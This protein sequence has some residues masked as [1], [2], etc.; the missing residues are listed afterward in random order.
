MVT[1]NNLEITNPIP[2]SGGPDIPKGL[3]RG[4][5]ALIKSKKSLVD[6]GLMKPDTTEERESAVELD[7][8]LRKLEVKAEESVKMRERIMEETGVPIEV[9][10]AL[11]D[12]IGTELEFAIKKN[13]AEI[14]ESFQ[15]ELSIQKSTI[16]RL[17]QEKDLL[18]SD[19]EKMKVDIENRI[20]QEFTK[21]LE[22]ERSKITIAAKES[23]SP[24][25]YSERRDLHDE[26]EK[27]L[28]TRLAEAEAR[29]E[30]EANTLVNAMAAQVAAEKDADIQNRLSR[31]REKHQKELTDQLANQAAELEEDF[32][33]KIKEI[34][35]KYEMVIEELE[36]KEDLARVQKEID[37]EKKAFD[38]Y[39]EHK[40]KAM[41][42]ERLTESLVLAFNTGDYDK[43]LDI[44]DRILEQEPKDVTMWNNRGVILRNMGRI[45]DAMEA[46][47]NAI[48]LDDQDVDP[49]FNLGF[50][51]FAREEMGKARVLFKK[52]LQID[53]DHEEARHFL[54]KIKKK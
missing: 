42:I 7:D 1:Q 29:W 4:L 28:T 30:E 39:M 54:R 43:A 11:E 5:G 10:K 2:L 17:K 9:R 36:V 40:Q 13:R 53:P 27:L 16:D 32:V 14:R 15:D 3:G 18:F 12:S 45:E 25:G 47:K 34:R 33:G 50:A 20:K 35:R 44:T 48:T 31:E 21:K 8:R 52:A 22:M 37:Q 6:G 38:H 49:I 41:E 23:G 46:Y 24:G 51:Y 19:M 26:Y